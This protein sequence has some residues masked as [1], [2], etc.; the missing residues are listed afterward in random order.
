MGVEGGVLFVASYLLTTAA[1]TRSVGAL[2][3][4]AAGIVSVRRIMIVTSPGRAKGLE[5]LPATMSLLSRGSVRTGRVAALG[6]IDS[7]MPGFFVPSCNSELASTVCVQKVKS[8][9]GAPTMNLCISGVPCVS[10]STFSFGFCSV[11]H[12]SVLH[13]PRKALCKHGA[14]KK[15]VGMRAHSPFSCRKASMGLDCKAGDG[16]HDTSLARCRH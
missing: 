16:C 15:L 3:G 4:S 10:G 12:V 1:F 8:H 2:P 7:L 6:G 11:R 14:V 5:R 13:N 9:V